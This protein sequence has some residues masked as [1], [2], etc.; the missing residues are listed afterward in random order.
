MAADEEAEDA[1][2][3]GFDWEDYDW[4][5]QAHAREAGR[6][7]EAARKKSESDL[8][9]E[10]LERYKNGLDHPCSLDDI[11]EFIDVKLPVMKKL[12]EL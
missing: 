3:K 5:G 2:K 4:K 1:V 10:M 7:R 6:A 8:M 11:M 12:R 9:H